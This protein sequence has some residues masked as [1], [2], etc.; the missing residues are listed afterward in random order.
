[1]EYSTHYKIAYYL[2]FL[3]FLVIN[4]YCILYE[5]RHNTRGKLQVIIVY[6]LTCSNFSCGKQNYR[7]RVKWPVTIRPRS[8]LILYTTS[9][10]I[11]AYICRSDCEP[12][13]LS[14]P[15]DQ[16]NALVL[17]VRVAS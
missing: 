4:C 5:M 3:H 12:Q 2:I 16:A 10:G 1:M 6:N 11:I 7:G 9:I 8:M 13:L 17:L 15:L 14:L